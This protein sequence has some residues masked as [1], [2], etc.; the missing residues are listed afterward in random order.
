MYVAAMCAVVASVPRSADASAAMERLIRE[1]GETIGFLQREGNK[2]FV[3]D[4]CFQ[5]LGFVTK[6]GTFRDTGIRKAR[7]PFPYLLLES[8]RN[9]A[10]NMPRR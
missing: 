3:K 9:C 4:R 6:D 5:T 10:R 2:T 1:A 8:E 7:S